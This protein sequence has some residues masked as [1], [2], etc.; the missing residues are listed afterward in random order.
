MCAN[1]LQDRAK[2]NLYPID[3]CGIEKMRFVEARAVQTARTRVDHHD[4]I[5]RR[6]GEI[7]LEAL[8]KF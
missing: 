6:C 2:V 5:E 1:L 4:E 8:V 7:Q 3:G